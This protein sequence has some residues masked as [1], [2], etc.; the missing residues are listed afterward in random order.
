MSKMADV[1]LI[2]EGTYPYVT[3]GVSTWTHELIQRQNHLT[4]HLVTILPRDGEFEKK[5][6]LPANV[7][8]HTDIRLQ[9]LPS[10]V[11]AARSL[12]GL[13]AS[14]NN[15][16]VGTAELRDMEH[17]IRTLKM[18]RGRP[19][20]DELLNSE[21]AWNLLIDMY[22]KHFAENSFLDYFWS[23]RSM[24]G[25]LY[26]ILLADIPDARVYHALS[27]GYAGLF[28]SRAKLEKQKPVIVTEHGIY[29]NE[30]RIEV[31]QAEW[32]A[33]DFSRA[34]TIDITHRSLRDF[35]IDTFTNY[36]RMCY[37]A[38][39]KIITLFEGNQ[40]AQ[41][42]DGAD[43]GK[44]EVIANGID[45]ARF[46]AVTRTAK[47]RPAIALIGRVVPIKDVKSYIRACAMLRAHIPDLKAY[48]IG[49]SEED[50]TYERECREMVDFLGLGDTIEFTGQVTVDDYLGQIDVLVMSSISEA[51]PLVILEAAAAG[52]PCVATNVGA[53]SE[54]ILGREDEDPSL[55]RGGAIVPLSN[56][57][58][59][60]EAVY[61]LLTDRELYESCSQ[62]AKARVSTYYTKDQ[63]YS[64][65]KA[66]YA[67]SM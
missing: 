43:R 60:A 53:C 27:T 39:D 44:M 64:A 61:E 59:I 34:L 48:I 32:L 47:S 26:S 17:V 67:T 9:R 41:V 62:A 35:W 50:D 18:F 56:P 52:I 38:A 12:D 46:A 57:L 29:T 40:L 28:A 13:E 6:T 11:M 25:S 21:E 20:E 65:Y 51:Q 24:M 54:M 42:A 33:E 58:A 15:I 23:W 37:E 7:I 3:G 8:G 19:G 45:V 5:Y 2:L 31:A 66:L 55:S 10:R 63:Q 14:L 22:E 49:P 1:C 4:F 36:S 16:T 30:R